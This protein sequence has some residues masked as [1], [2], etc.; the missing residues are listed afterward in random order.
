MKKIVVMALIS[1]SLVAVIAVIGISRMNSG[2]P[3]AEATHQA[4]VVILGCGPA[5]AEDHSNY[6]VE[7]YSGSEKAPALG[8][9]VSMEDSCAQALV[10]LGNN[11]FSVEGKASGAFTHGDGFSYTLRKENIRHV[12]SDE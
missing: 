12:T 8:T 6:L 7:G 2:V 3:L 10:A 9:I 1:I 5:E 11:G 4:T